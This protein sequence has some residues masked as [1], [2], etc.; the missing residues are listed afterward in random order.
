MDS[1]APPGRTPGPKSGLFMVMGSIVIVCG[2]IL[3]ACNPVDSDEDGFRNPAT[4]VTTTTA[5]TATTTTTVPVSTARWEA[6]GLEYQAQIP[7]EECDYLVDATLAHDVGPEAPPVGDF[8]PCDNWT[9]FEVG[10][11]GGRVTSLGESEPMPNVYPAGISVLARLR[12]LD[13]FEGAD[14][15]ADFG[16]LAQL[17]SL[18]NNELSVKYGGSGSGLVA[19]TSISLHWGSVSD[20]S[21][22]WIG[23]VPNLR[24]IRAHRRLRIDPH[25]PTGFVCFS[26]RVGAAG[27]WGGS[28]VCQQRFHLH[29]ARG[30][31]DEF[32]QLPRHDRGPS[33][34]DSH[35]DRRAD[36][37]ER[38]GPCGA[39][40]WT[41]SAARVATPWTAR[42]S[43]TASG[44]HR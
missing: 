28:G 17:E 4:T 35:L 8:Q 25:R 41:G 34:R 29:P 30:P 19:L 20:G 32:A 22:D 24:N 13:L 14:L 1:S 39:V 21:F 3:A 26:H 36:R 42:S 37:I 23:E 38:V 18:S 11:A 40:W 5:T 10:C 2:L 31:V 44:R 6:C 27:S 43:L 15:P 7:P 16:D 33:C 9:V 12:T